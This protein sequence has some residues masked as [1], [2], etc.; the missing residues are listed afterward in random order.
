MFSFDTRDALLA[1]LELPLD[2]RLHRL[3]T[4]RVRDAMACELGDMTH[5]LVVQAGDT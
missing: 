2:L 5:I 3:L 1:A 4:D